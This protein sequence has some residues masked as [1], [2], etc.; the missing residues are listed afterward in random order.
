[1]YIGYRLG[2]H[3]P[4]AN[5]LALGVLASAPLIFMAVLYPSF[6]ADQGSYL[7]TRNWVLGQDYTGLMPFHYRPPL[8]GMALVPVTWFVGD[9]WAG[10][11]LSIVSMWCIGGAGYY[12]ARAWLPP[13][14]A[15]WAAA[16][17]TVSPVIVS[18]AIGGYL[19]V[20][21]LA[22][23]FV[24][25]RT[26]ITPSRASWWAVPV[27]SFV[28]SGLNQTIPVNMALMLL[29][30]PNLLW[31]R[32]RVG[33]LALGVIATVPW[34]PWL[35]VNGGEAGSYYGESPWTLMY[36]HVRMWEWGVLVVLIPIAYG[37]AVMRP[38]SPVFTAWVVAAV[39]SSLFA[40]HIVAN[41]VLARCTVY[42]PVWLGI[43]LVHQYG[44]AMES[45]FSRLWVWPTTL[46]VFF[47]G[48]SV[49]SI[50]NVPAYNLLDQDLLD[51]LAYIEERSAVEDKV[52]G[53]PPGMGRWIGALTGRAWGASWG[54]DAPKVYDSEYA[55]FRCVVGWDLCPSD[56][57]SQFRWFIAHW[58]VYSATVMERTQTELT[59][60]YMIPAASG[61]S[62]IMTGFEVI[63]AVVP[64]E[65]ALYVVERPGYIWRVEKGV[66]ERVLALDLSEKVATDHIEQGLLNLAFGPD[67]TGYIYYTR[68]GDGAVE[69]ATLEGEVML[70]IPQ[71]E[72]HHNGGGMS[73]GPDGF[74]YLGIGDGGDPGRIEGLLGSIVRL[75]VETLEEKRW[76]TGFRNPWRIAWGE[77][78]LWVADVGEHRFEEIN[79]VR[80][81]RDYGWPATE[82]EG[83]EYTY[84]T[85]S[86]CAIIGGVSYQ[87]GFVFGDF[88]SREVYLWKEGEAQL[89][90]TLPEPMSG[91]TL[92]GETLL[93]A[94]YGGTVY[95]YGDIGAALDTQGSTSPLE[96]RWEQGDVQVYEVMR[97]TTLRE[98]VKGRTWPWEGK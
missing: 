81:G 6:G 34:W 38:R 7:M 8:I 64:T 13:R 78:G 85:R 59:A 40:D 25:I 43:H 92:D 52:G 41:N 37:A 91:F 66:G 70:V 45:A 31:D 9:L 96:L 56:Q 15:L 28:L 62:P 79:L 12:L 23:S 76:A 1:M 67:G 17:A 5:A 11:I 47:V 18:L 97:P 54:D 44:D 35:W 75:D 36:S 73:W 39:M 77:R 88:C 86:G 30:F 95:A 3:T 98:D 55:D 72:K 50:V 4:F 26:V 24:I 32:R 60:N 69:I 94:G 29:A 87:G 71:P 16:F 42:I 51:G 65:G 90:G 80:E 83:A 46:G 84:P 10:K 27:L 14:R 93:V 63:T 53:Y 82:G 58:G 21:A 33:I 57:P 49:T 22:L 20:L 68:A 61:F 19:S 74:L 48:V 89:L 2:L